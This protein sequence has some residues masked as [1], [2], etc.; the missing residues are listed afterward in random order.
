MPIP[1]T[2]LV[3]PGR[4]TCAA[5]LASLLSLAAAAGAQP[6]QR[7]TRE[8]AVAAALA[9]APRATLLRADS[10]AA[11]A[12]VT[13]ARQWDNP[14]L[15]AAYSQSAP[16]QH[17]GLD[18]P[19]DFPWLRRARIGSAEAAAGAARWRYQFDRAALGF[20]V[21][22]AY[23]HALASASRAVLSRANVL[24]ADS[25]VVLARLRRDAGDGTD[26]DVQLSEV[27]AGQ[28]ANRAADDSL[29][30]SSALLVVQALMGLPTDR[31]V[32][33]LADTLAAPAFAESAATGEPLLVAAAVDAEHSAELGATLERRRV[34]GSASLQAGFEA[35]DPSQ[36]PGALPTIGLSI[37]IPLFNRNDG[38]VQLA[39]AEHARA[40][41]ELALARLEAAS[42]VTRARRALTLALER[43]ARDRRLL[44]GAGR[45]SALSL[46]AYREGAAA[47]PSVLEAQ[48]TAREAL[49]TYIDDVAAARTAAGVVRLLTL[50]ANRT[51]P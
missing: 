47:L 28:M 23:T 21:D 49:A 7:V 8:D 17:Y 10:A 38:A 11:R 35:G 30:R 37:P 43:V 2:H 20:E 13:S 29:E 22:T 41:A 46:L 31:V 48:R 24:A 39:D 45:V 44:D 6:Q 32:I 26:L 16:T 33:A 50:T 4:A 34:F 15:S 3:L 14:T 9:T 1:V 42:Q 36:P 27:N 18:L 51:Q 12:R 40:R 5:I 25:L 19:L